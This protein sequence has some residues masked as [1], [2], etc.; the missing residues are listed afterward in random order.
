MERLKANPQSIK[1][2]Y[3]EENQADALF[4]RKKAKE[5][6][7]PVVTVP[8]SRL[9][10]AGRDIRAQGILVEIEDFRYVPYEAMLETALKEKHSLVFLDNLNDPQNL[11][12]MMRSMAC[13]GGFSIVLP[14]H[15]SVG[16]TEAVLRVA[17]GGDNYVSVA[18]VMN[19]SRAVTMAKETGFWLAGAVT[20]N[21]RP[22]TEAALPFPL[23]LVVGSEH[24]GVRDILRK[25]LD[26][27]L[28]IP[29]AHLGL[30]LNVA[31]A[32]TILCYEVARQRKQKRKESQA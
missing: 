17:T 3:L 18:R 27:E 28:T 6:G 7:I 20:Q 23:G 11:G 32:T 16:V 2:I 22:L 4:I 10:K 29:M 14:T 25:Q 8:R 9:I 26:L 31:Q 21:G 13:L 1:R 19:L 15:E 30:S 5:H 12:A 24:K